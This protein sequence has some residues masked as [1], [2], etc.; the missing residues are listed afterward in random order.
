MCYFA[1]WEEETLTRHFYLK[2]AVS[3]EKEPREFSWKQTNQQ[4]TP[5]SKKQI[6]GMT[7]QE[8]KTATKWNSYL[9]VLLKFLISQQGFCALLRPAE[10]TENELEHKGVKSVWCCCCCSSTRKWSITL[11]H[12]RLK[13]VRIGSLIS[14]DLNYLDAETKPSNRLPSD[15]YSPLLQF[16]GKD[17]IRQLSAMSGIALKLKCRYNE[18]A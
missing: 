12:P 17:E 8:M 7:H 14:S 4:Q 16:E 11:V 13:E 10:A 1:Q 2:D 3:D 6:R 18:R 5:Y 9:F 15:R